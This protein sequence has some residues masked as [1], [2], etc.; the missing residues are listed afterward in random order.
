VH[1]LA[2]LSSPT[3]DEL[4]RLAMVGIR[5]R[6]GAA[7][8]QKA[9]PTTGDVTRLLATTSPVSAAGARDRTVLLLG[10]AGGFR[11]SELVALD[12]EDVAESEQG[13]RIR[14]RRSKTDQEGVGRE[15]GIGASPLL[16]S[17][18]LAR[19]TSIGERRTSGMRPSV[20][21]RWRRTCSS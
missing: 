19:C 11:R 1:R 9:A 18:L 7:P 5:R 15:L 21:I 14:I 12:V 4:V 3:A 20:G 13:L 2:R 10:F 16:R 17:S 6:H 8:N